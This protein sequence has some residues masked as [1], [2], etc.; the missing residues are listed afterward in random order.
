M[1]QQLI[2]RGQLYRLKQEWFEY[3][4]WEGR[5]PEYC[6]AI[7]CSYNDGSTI[8]DV[9]IVNTDKQRHPLFSQN[10][11]PHAIHSLQKV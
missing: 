4:S 10:P 3:Y 5:Y 9:W 2:K 11:M 6:Y 8:V 1:P 7:P